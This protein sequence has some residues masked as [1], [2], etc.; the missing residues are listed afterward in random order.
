MPQ[1]LRGF[2]GART[3]AGTRSE[4]AAAEKRK[5]SWSA[6]PHPSQIKALVKREFLF[7][8]NYA[9]DDKTN[10][11]SGCGLEILFKT[12]LQDWL[13]ISYEK[14]GQHFGL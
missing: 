12:R 13:Q 3:R 10:I 14:E 7:C 9:V 8:C 1:A 5:R 6:I 11:Y 2:G 4:H